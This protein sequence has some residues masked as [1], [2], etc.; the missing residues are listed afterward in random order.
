M[1]LMNFVW[2]CTHIIILLSYWFMSQHLKMNGTCDDGAT[3]LF[4]DFI[5][6]LSAHRTV[7]CL[8]YVLLYCLPLF[9]SYPGF[10]SLSIWY[11]LLNCFNPYND[12]S[13]ST[14]Y[15]LMRQESWCEFAMCCSI[16][17]IWEINVWKGAGINN[18]W[19]T[20]MIC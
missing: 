10:C 15:L 17:E 19:W 18:R 5:Y 1:I 20:V 11:G 4:N 8:I 16:I 12:K 9:S 7:M 2:T 6:V 14:I 3:T 13:V